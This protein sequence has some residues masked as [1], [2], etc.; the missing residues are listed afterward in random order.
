MYIIPRLIVCL[1]FDSLQVCSSAPRTERPPCEMDQSQSVGLDGQPPS[2]VALCSSIPVGDISSVEYLRQDSTKDREKGDGSDSG[3]EFGSGGVQSLERLPNEAL[4][5]A[6]TP[7]ADLQAVRSTTNSKDNESQRIPPNGE[8]HREV[9]ATEGLYSCDSS[10]RSFCSDENLLGDGKA[11]NTG[12][13]SVVRDCAS[14]GGGS[15]SSSVYNQPVMPSSA[16]KRSN[17]VLGR[18]DK[19]LA[20]CMSAST[21][22]LSKPDTLARAKFRA[23]SVNRVGPPALLTKERARSKERGQSG[24][25]SPLVRANSLRRPIKPDSLPVV[26]PMAAPSKRMSTLGRTQSV[27]TPGTT[28]SDSGRWPYGPGSGSALGTP[29]SV[30]RTGFNDSVV[31]V[32]TR[33]GQ[34][35]LDHGGAQSTFDKYATMP[36]RRRDRSTDQKASHESSTR[37]SSISRD[38]LTTTTKLSIS[39]N[40]QKSTPVARE[41][42]TP[43]MRSVVRRLTQKVSIFHE[44][45]IQ[46]LLTH[47]DLDNAFEG[48]VTVIDAS[49]RDKASVSTQSEIR[50]NEME[51]LRTQVK[52]LQ[53][54]GE[55]MRSA[56]GGKSIL[57]ASVEQ[58]LVK[59]RE[60]K[61]KLQ[62]EL[63]CN[64]ERVVA[65]LESHTTDT[66]DIM[67]ESTD[68]LMM[69]ETKVTT[70]SQVVA[71][72][73]LE[74]KKM[75]NVC[76]ALRLELDEALE[77][78][79]AV[80]AERESEEM[81]EFLQIEKSVLTD[82][83]KTEEKAKWQIVVE[84][85]DQEIKWLLEECRHLVRFCEQR[86]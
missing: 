15:E 54:E 75:R 70:D 53:D 33:L 27:R 21:T 79:R 41:P 64:S 28:P 80:I 8:L 11:H 26:S 36:R 7:M 55:R 14:E 57:L 66:G 3:I 85:K 60:S 62:K 47:Q 69:L 31:V 61:V 29:R 25:G 63:Q 6:P 39:T 17:G 9:Y 77:R 23:S 68:S 81:Q 40:S 50:D 65:I 71:K 84:K 58:Q 12:G 51:E 20:N 56:L 86:R 13:R 10:V 44:K 37:S 72:Q 73:K 24:G 18:D 83:A 74:L 48:K 59:E 22:Q 45:S 42:V 82:A 38:R 4:Q 35:S 49:Q 5:L 30:P 76:M 2:P 32:K 19:L 67:G 16:K 1:N 52:H 78:E 34:L 43:K 46:T